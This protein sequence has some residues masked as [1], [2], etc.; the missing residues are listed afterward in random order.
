MIQWSGQLYDNPT[1][2]QYLT[3]TSTQ[4]GVYE[5]FDILHIDIVKMSFSTVLMV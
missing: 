3:Y 2:G 4:N 5:K 1:E